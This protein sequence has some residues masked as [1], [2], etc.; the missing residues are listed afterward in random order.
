MITTAE[1]LPSP[2]GAPLP[3]EVMMHDDKSTMPNGA[4]AGD[5]QPPP[6]LSHIHKRSWMERW[7][8]IKPYFLPMI[9]AFFIQFI[10]GI[11]DSQLGI[12][13]PSIKAH[14]GLSQYVV[15][16]IFLCNTCGYMMAAVS[17]GFLIKYLSQ[18]KTALIGSISMVLGFLVILFALPFPV[19][20]VFMVAVGFG[21]ALTQ[22]SSNVVCGEMPHNTLMLSFLHAFYGAGG[23]IGPLLASAILA[24]GQPWNTSY[25]VMC[26]FAG[27]NTLSIL[28]CYRKLRIRSEREADAALAEKQL[29]NESNDDNNSDHDSLGSTCPTVVSSTE[30]DIES[31]DGKT[32]EPNL[33]SQVLNYRICYVG[34]AF[35]LF[36][37]GTEVTIGNWGYTFLITARS[38]DTVAMA[39]VMSGYWAGI[40]AGRLFLGFVTSRFG[41][42]RMVYVYLTI[43]V[44]MLILLWLIPYIGANATALVVTGFTLGPIFPTTVSVA[45]QIMPTKLYATAVGFLSAFASAGTAVFPYATGVLI[46]SQGVQAMLPFCVAT[47]SCMWLLWLFMPDPRRGNFIRPLLTRL[48]R[49]L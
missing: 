9:Q 19:M 35:L 44:A 7:Q 45:H 12:M 43:I 26:G 1:H 14:Y 18:A 22:A 39:H 36:Y 41:E 11:N 4:T 2:S 6:P 31:F 30:D 17:N 25:K 33:L 49:Q 3:T 32:K 40:C 10:T 23:L 28:I 13:L 38:S 29:Q 16:I 27:F 21:V 15:S 5:G 20:C 37:T 47:S 8:T 34:C 42:K 46:G 24:Q 48:R